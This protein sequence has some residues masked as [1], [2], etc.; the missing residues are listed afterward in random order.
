MNAM[1]SP[2]TRIQKDYEALLVQ[3]NLRQM[4]AT[5][6][7]KGGFIGALLPLLA[8]HAIPA[9]IGGIAQMA[10]PKRRYAGR[11]GYSPKKRRK[12]PTAPPFDQY[13]Y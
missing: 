5:K 10:A 7:Q 2:Q 1:S 6:R 4:P 11:G 3:G 8:R 13:V 9:V 12:T